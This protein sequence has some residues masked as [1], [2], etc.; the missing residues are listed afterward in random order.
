[1]IL[2]HVFFLSHSVCFIFR[3]KKNKIGLLCVM[4][5]LRLWRHP[6]V[7]LRLFAL[8]AWDNI[9]V[10]LWLLTSRFFLLGVV[11]AVLMHVVLVS[12]KVGLFMEINRLLWFAIWWIGLGVLS[13]IGLGT[14]MH[15]GMLFLFPH[16]LQVCLA[17]NACGHMDFESTKDVWFVSGPLAFACTYE[18]ASPAV[19][20]LLQLVLKALPAALLW[21]AGLFQKNNT[22]E[23]FSCVC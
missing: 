8:E 12:L 1:V 13:S 4:G 19:P 21:G 9:T 14:G 11:P 5:R 6:L 10:Y 23:L 15:T 22:K 16:I 7:V 20:T 2:D 3:Q 17:A 18:A